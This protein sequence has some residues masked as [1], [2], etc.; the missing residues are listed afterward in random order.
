MMKLNK[1]K[2]I[3]VMGILIGGSG[4]SFAQGKSEIINIEQ[5]YKRQ[6]KKMLTFANY[7]RS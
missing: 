2:I 7:N 4:S 5:E 3:V 6:K 1:F